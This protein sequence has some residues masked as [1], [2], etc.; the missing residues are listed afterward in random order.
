MHVSVG[1]RYVEDPGFRA[2]HDALAS[3]LA[4]W[5]HEIIEASARHH[6]VDPAAV[7]WK[8]PPNRPTK[9]PRG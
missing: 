3:G 4:R 6:G 7:T 9:S 2:N 8:Y 1:R 5:L